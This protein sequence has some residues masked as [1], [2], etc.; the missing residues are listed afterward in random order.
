[1]TNQIQEKKLNRTDGG[2][3]LIEVIIAIVILALVTIPLLSYFTDSLQHSVRMARQQRATLAAQEITESLKAV[4]RLIEKPEGQT[5]YSVPYLNILLDDCK[6]EEGGFNADGT[7]SATYSGVLSKESE[8]FD[9]KVKISTSTSANAVERPLIYGIDDAKDVMILERDQKE[10]ALT[11]FTSVNVN[12]CSVHPDQ[13]ILSQ[14]EIFAKM[15]RTINILVDN[16]QED[17]TD[18]ESAY[19]TV[20]AYYDYKCVGL[21]GT[22]SSDT[23]ACTYLVNSKVSALKNIY[24]LYNCMTGVDR[25]KLDVSEE[26]YKKMP[27]FKEDGSTLDTTRLGLYLIAQNYD[28]DK[29]ESLY[30]E[31]YDRVW[32]SAHTNV[33]SVED[34]LGTVTAKSLTATGSPTRLI[35]IKTEV[36]K[37]GHEDT[38]DA[39]IVVETTKGE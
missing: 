29:N 11:Y 17:P 4:K 21:R 27:T 14:D 38:D 22:G 18:D 19:F 9:V 3:S 15:T 7:G 6:L 37:K 13:T 24:L 12:Y 26:A 34:A 5:A 31:G 30:L 20:K 16:I 8:S 33:D 32:M 2:F 28:P 39:L 35:E 25:I 10:E 23:Y 36:Y 1:M